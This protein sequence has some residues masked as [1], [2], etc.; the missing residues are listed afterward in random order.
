MK[1][2]IIA[3]QQ[4]HPLCKNNSRL[5]VNV[6]PEMSL[7]CALNKFTQHEGIQIIKLMHKKSSLLLGFSP[8]SSAGLLGYLHRPIT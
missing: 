1:I 2:Q 7:A 3:L 4:G 6:N 8:H 5:A